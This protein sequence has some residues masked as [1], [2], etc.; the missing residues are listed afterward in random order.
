M[1]GFEI[2][3]SYATLGR[4]KPI[5][6]LEYKLLKKGPSLDH[7]TI[8][9]H[10]EF[11]RRRTHPAVVKGLGRCCLKDGWGNGTGCE[12]P[13]GFRITA[14]PHFCPF[15]PALLPRSARNS[16]C[17]TAVVENKS[18]RAE[19]NATEEAERR[20]SGVHVS[21]SSGIQ[22]NPRASLQN[23][24]P[25]GDSLESQAGN[26]QTPKPEQTLASDIPATNG[27]NGTGLEGRTSL[28]G[29][30]FGGSA[31]AAREQNPA[32]SGSS[33]SVANSQQTVPDFKV[34]CAHC[35]RLHIDSHRRN[36]GDKEHG[37]RATNMG[38]I[39]KTLASKDSGRRPSISGD[40]SSE[41]QELVY[42][43]QL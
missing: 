35:Y 34:F 20:K 5:T 14:W 36:L 22:G 21:R 3:S 12:A 19:G 23:Q 43:D 13:M 11:N 1:P 27:L 26:G 42:Y 17:Q 15:C 7:L 18:P 39:S 32:L 8:I 9:D 6:F 4:Y 40:R 33:K 10:D 16:E 30:W 31:M 24:N 29:S 38:T 2:E 41:S 28:F 25:N 37:S